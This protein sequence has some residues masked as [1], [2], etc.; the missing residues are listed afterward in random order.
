MIKKIGEMCFACNGFGGKLD[1]DIILDEDDSMEVLPTPA[2]KSTTRRRAKEVEESEC[3]SDDE[4]S[5]SV[6]TSTLS[7]RASKTAALTKMTVKS[8]I[9]ID[10][11][12]DEEDEE[13]E[14]DSQSE[15]TSDYDSDV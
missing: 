2:P 7:Q 10:E 11:Y 14:A 3:S 12:D 9:K 1:L 13:E 15:V 8:T 4:L 6:V 5:Q